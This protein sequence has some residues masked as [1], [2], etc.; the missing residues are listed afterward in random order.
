[1]YFPFHFVPMSTSRYAIY[2]TPPPDS[3]LAAF[4]AGVIGYDCFARSDVPHRRIDGI[5]PSVLALA[6]TE[7]RRYGFHATLMAPFHLADGTDEDGLANAFSA[8]ATSHV[9]IATGLL[10]VTAM[11]RFVVLSTVEPHPAIEDLADACLAAF[12]PY[13]APLTDAD[14]ARRVAVG[15]SPRQA[16]LLERWGYPYVFEEFRFHMTLAG[17]VPDEA[18]AAFKASLSKAFNDLS[19]DHL[20]LGAISLMRQDDQAGRFYVLER[21][22]LSARV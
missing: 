10:R 12:D 7:P 17:P 15:L 9:P 14:R 13:R 21:R 4:G 22:R 20:E 5:D 1:V 3:P 16:E 2:F 19:R 6:T 11:N 18:R 8:F